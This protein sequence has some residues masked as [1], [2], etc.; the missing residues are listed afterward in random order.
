MT[1][2]MKQRGIR[3]V[4][5]IG[6]VIAGTLL[7]A[8]ACN[9]F[10]RCAAPSPQQLAQLPRQLS[11]TGLY[12]DLAA[13]T[14]ASGVRAFAPR[15][16]LWSDGASKRRWVFLPPGERIDTRDMDFWQFPQGT[17]LWK[18]FIRD[19][20]RVE[21]RLLQKVGP[22]EG[23]W[24]AMAYVWNAEQ[25]AALG[26]PAGA[27]DANGTPHDVPSAS[28]CMGCHG[29]TRSRVLGFSAIQLAHE[30]PAGV[31]DLQ[32]LLSEGAL[33]EPPKGPLEVPGNDTE[34]AALGYLHANCGHCHN[35]QRPSQH[36]ERCF[37]PQNE[38]DFW[39]RVDRLGSVHETPTYQSAIGSGFGPIETGN[40]GDSRLIHRVSTRDDAAM[41]PLGTE[42]VDARMVELLHRWIQQL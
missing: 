14:L 8:C 17:R 41:P 26:T 36:G 2:D 25:T 12:A 23:D 20:V 11:E 34:R 22:G 37:A 38:L 3:K 29:G 4:L 5:G 21:T 18:E 42:V 33:T 39:L 16:E 19:G 10:R 32:A 30:A 15:Y 31:L 40:P 28:Q 7:G 13:G 9:D 6:G 27:T 24:A 1:T 35:Q